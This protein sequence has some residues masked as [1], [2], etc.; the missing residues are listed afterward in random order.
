M[1]LSTAHGAKQLSGECISDTLGFCSWL[2]SPSALQTSVRIRS[3][4]CNVCW[5]LLYT[6][7]QDS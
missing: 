6:G 5:L 7:V 3:Q 2:L 1:L 4:P